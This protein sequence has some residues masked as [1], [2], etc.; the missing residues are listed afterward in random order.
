VSGYAVREGRYFIE[1]DYA[2]CSKRRQNT[3]GD[4]FLSNKIREE[5]RSIAILSDG[6]GSGIKA[7]VL[8][9]LTSVMASRFVSSFRDVQ[10]TAEIIMKTLPVCRQRKISYATFTI[11]DIDGNGNA[12]I[13]EY[14]NPPVLIIRNK[15]ALQIETS[16]IDGRMGT[17]RRYT[18]HYSRFPLDYEDRVVLFS[19]GVVQAGMG[20]ARFPLGWGWD[21]AVAWMLK[22]VNE[23]SG[24]SATELSDSVVK[25]A[26]EIDGGCAHDDISCAVI[27][28]RQPRELMIVSG[29]PLDNKNDTFIAGLLAG[30]AGSKVICGGTTA[31]I[32]SREL[33][34]PVHFDLSTY[35][36]T[37]PPQSTMEGIDLVTEGIITLQRT[38]EILRAGRT[39][40]QGP[41]SP[42]RNLVGIMLRNDIVRFI[43]GTRI[44]E[45][46]QDPSL[47]EDI[48]LRR[49]IVN[50]LRRLLE[51]DYGK[52]V[53]V[54]YV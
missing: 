36:A 1:I 24:R 35:D 26:L 34:R 11:V 9:T 46:W 17:K 16:A 18:L 51:R 54:Q 21:N 22:C 20:T 53:V 33:H 41:P 10:K 38:A 5:N 12:C 27:Y 7:A 29:P 31:R 19:D 23:E 30:H 2:Q 32:I 39:A 14:D 48:G 42:A 50:D 47:P 13:V 44:N 8:S 40:V 6:L 52:E 25:K 3:C 4:T 15:A 45:A 37:I 49:T 28:Y 43:T